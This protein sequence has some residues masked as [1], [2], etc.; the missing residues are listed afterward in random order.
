MT[1]PTYQYFYTI[2]AWMNWSY[3]DINLDQPTANNS[4]YSGVYTTALDNLTDLAKQPPSFYCL[5]RES[6]TK[7]TSKTAPAATTFTLPIGYQVQYRIRFYQLFGGTY[8]WLTNSYVTMHNATS[9]SGFTLGKVSTDHNTFSAGPNISHQGVGDTFWFTISPNAYVASSTT[10]FTLSGTITAGGLNGDSGTYS[11]SSSML[12]NVNPTVLGVPV[13]KGQ[14]VPVTPH[15]PQSFLDVISSTPSGYSSPIPGDYV[16]DY[17][18]Q[19]WHGVF[20]APNTNLAGVKTVVYQ[21]YESTVSGKP[22]KVGGLITDKDGSKYKALVAEFLTYTMANCAAPANAVGPKGGGGGG[23]GG[24]TT[25]PATGGSTD[26]AVTYSPPSG[27]VRWNPPPHKFARDTQYAQRVANN[28]GW[29]LKGTAPLDGI[30][31]PGT[32]FERGRLFQDSTGAQILNKVTP[33]KGKTLGTVNQWGF[34]FMY[35]PTSFMYQTSTL[36]NIDWTL[37]PKNSAALLAGNSQVSFDLYINRI[38]DM[39]YLTNYNPTNDLSE[40]AVYGR[41]LNTEERLGIANRG[42]EYDI[43]FLY[44]VLNGDPDSSPLLFNSNYGGESSDFGYTTAVPCWL[45][46]NDNMRYYGSMAS[47]SVNHVIFDARMVPI[48]SVVSVTFSRI[49][50]LG[51][52]AATGAHTKGTTPALLKAAQDAANGV[53]TP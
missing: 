25:P 22:T 6:S 40:S 17:C 9:V 41:E 26:V 33:G 38:P 28:N 45:W 14:K 32:T 18:N 37:G 39:R 24:G 5:Y 15:V 48:L 34:R 7:N 47:F 43:E 30:F 46:L 19:K 21:E 12:L 49:P 4:T 36:N 20:K 3:I 16:W 31:N 50:A 35:N 13:P 1:T 2:E 42:T 53:G 23:G 44:R 8:Y 52:D 11:I 10:P 27:D 29:T 51:F